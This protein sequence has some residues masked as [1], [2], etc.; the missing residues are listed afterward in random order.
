[1]K[2]KLIENTN[3]AIDGGFVYLIFDQWDDYG[4]CTTFIAY[5]NNNTIEN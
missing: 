3:E 4:Y 5:Y 1:M 2:F